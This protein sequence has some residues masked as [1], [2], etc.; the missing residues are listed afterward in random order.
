MIIN[1]TG[2][3]VDLTEL[4]SYSNVGLST[5][6]FRSGTQSLQVNIIPS[7]A[8]IGTDTE[9][10]Y[11]SKYGVLR[12]YFR[13][14]TPPQSGTQEI[15]R[16]HGTGNIINLRLT[17]SRQLQLFDN[18]TLLSTHAT[19]LNLNTWYRIEIGLFPKKCKVLLDGVSVITSTIV[20]RVF[21][22]VYLGAAVNRGMG[23][24]SFF[25]DD[26]CLTEDHFPGEGQ[27]VNLPGDSNF[28]ISSGS[29]YTSSVGS[30]SGTIRYVKPWAKAKNAGTTIVHE[31]GNNGKIYNNTPSY[32]KARGPIIPANNF[33]YWNSQPNLK[34]LN[35]GAGSI[36]VQSSGVMVEYGTQDEPDVQF[37]GLNDSSIFYVDSNMTTNFSSPTLINF[38][39]NGNFSCIVGH[40]SLQLVGTTL[41]F[42]LSNILTETRTVNTSGNI[43]LALLNYQGT[44]Y[45]LLLNNSILF[46]GIDLNS[47]SPTSINMEF[48]F[49]NLIVTKDYFHTNVELQLIQITG[50]GSQSNYSGTLTNATEY[51]IN[52][53][54]YITLTG[55]NYFA[56]TQIPYKIF[57]IRQVYKAEPNKQIT[58][59]NR[60]F[61]TYSEIHAVTEQWN[62]GHPWQ[63]IPELGIYF[64]GILYGSYYVILKSRP[65]KTAKAFTIFF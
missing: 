63:N 37:I 10:S 57:C 20:D 50:N 65:N 23:F 42:Y 29:E 28:S 52:S 44:R 8:E 5:T 34:F 48:N 11:T 36:S 47:F 13:V 27:I 35:I 26:V 15:M 24:V 3:E 4:Q 61:T 17:S 64:N 55:Q 18:N 54:D 39:Y 22:N 14:A 45:K 53:S 12:F 46:S 60:E 38:D 32:S 41:S 40:I 58:I 19:A 9:Q 49:S 43:K 30:Y 1:A 33:E 59:F 56:T 51:P 16:Y 21:T 62:E 25:Y 2:F 6:T 7:I 31:S